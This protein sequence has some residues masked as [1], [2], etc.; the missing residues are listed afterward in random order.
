MDEVEQSLWMY[1]TIT[2]ITETNLKTKPGYPFC[3]TEFS[4]LYILFYCWSG[5]LLDYTYRGQFM[6][7]INAFFLG[8]IQM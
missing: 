5:P 2:L 4:C 3:N 1:I 7:K 6:S 8:F